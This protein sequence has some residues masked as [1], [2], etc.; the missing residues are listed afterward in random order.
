MQYSAVS[1]IIL[2]EFGEIELD[3]ESINTQKH[4]LTLPVM[5]DHFRTIPNTL[6]H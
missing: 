1:N 5:P 2:K 4:A 6:E 3:F